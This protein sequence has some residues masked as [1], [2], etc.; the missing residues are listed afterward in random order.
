M[1]I[2]AAEKRKSRAPSI[3]TV[4]EEC[5]RNDNIY[6]R[7]F[8]WS[9]CELRSVGLQDTESKKSCGASVEKANEE[10]SR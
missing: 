2:Q 3:G 10:I 7:G 4:I 8:C 6:R 1:P 5:T 9:A